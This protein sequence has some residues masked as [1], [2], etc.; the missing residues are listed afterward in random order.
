MLLITLTDRR[1]RHNHAPNDVGNAYWHLYEVLF[2]SFILSCQRLR[3][4]FQL[5]MFILLLCV[6]A[7]KV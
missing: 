2:V 6:Q 1:Y 3:I 5:L 7:I 4:S